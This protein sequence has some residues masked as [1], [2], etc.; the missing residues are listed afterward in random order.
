VSKGKGNALDESLDVVHQ[1]EF[2]GVQSP[3]QQLLE[4]DLHVLEEQDLGFCFDLD[5]V[6]EGG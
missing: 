2:V 3:L 5:A 1:K 4:G 6:F